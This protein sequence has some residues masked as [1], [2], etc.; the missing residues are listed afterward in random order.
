MYDV[1]PIRKNLR[2]YNVKINGWS[3]V[4]Y[5]VECSATLDNSKIFGYVWPMPYILLKYGTYILI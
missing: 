4:Y 3:I 2:I 1:L 5:V